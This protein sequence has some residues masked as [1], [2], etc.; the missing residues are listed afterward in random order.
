MK[1]TNIL[2]LKN[3]PRISTYSV[4]GHLVAVKRK[5]LLGLDIQK[6]ID[7]TSGHY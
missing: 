4:P 7:L 1:F 6:K 3:S 5:A 2:K